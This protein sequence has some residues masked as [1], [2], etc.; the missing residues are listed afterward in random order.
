MIEGGGAMNYA[1][2]AS[3]H[4]LTT[5]EAAAR[6]G[7]KP[8]TLYAYVSRG[9]L[10]SERGADGRTS[11][12][13]TDEIERFAARGRRPGPAPDSAQRIESAISVIDGA[14]LFYR[15]QGALALARTRT[16]EE[17]A[18]WLW[19]SAI[20]SR[21]VWRADPVA[22]I[23]GAGAQAPLSA[24]TL[25]LDRLRV[26]AAAVATTDD[27][28]TDL[29]AE[30]V[31]TAARSLIAA[32][33]DCL[34]RLRPELAGPLALGGAAAPAGALAARLWVRLCATA[35]EPG[36]VD[37]LNT[38][39]V[40]LADHELSP[41]TLAVRIAASVRADPYAAVCTGLGAVSGSLHGAASLAVEDLLAEI[42]QPEQA[43]GVIGE[44][45]R[46]GEQIPGAGHPLYPGGDPRT[47]ALLASLQAAAAGHDRAA[48]VE[49]TIESMRERGLPAPNVDF[50]LG[51]LARVA[52]MT[53]GAG[54]AIV[55]V[56]RTAGW[57]AHAL[58]E[59]ARPS[60]YRPRASYVGPRPRA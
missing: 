15:G 54:E 22:I 10:R 45:L 57:I 30:S 21:G 7:V 31:C 42:H 25:P 11:Y 28:R 3:P 40:L 36:M 46:R 8:D 58:E 9:L 14:R 47:V 5:A 60:S 48:T 41:S 43:D 34:P 20:P 18:E 50:A 51:A 39:L 33:V 55:A 6:L 19:T 49:A 29:R 24:D 23:A 44:R 53:R 12:F 38:A 1:E 26:I 32:M 13:Q 35:P 4:R 56:A 2:G 17:T 52:G 59:Y 16:F 27:Q 37:A